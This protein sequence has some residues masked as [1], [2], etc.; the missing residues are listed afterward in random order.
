VLETSRSDGSKI[1]TYSD[2]IVKLVDTSGEEEVYFV[3]GSIMKKEPNGECTITWPS[4]QKEVRT[5]MYVKRIYTN[6]TVKTMYADGSEETRY[7]NGRVRR[8]NKDGVL[9]DDTKKK[10]KP[11]KNDTSA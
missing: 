3:D 10:M 4:G 8:K 7:W 5:A 1:Y 9:V 11:K 6:G 2:G